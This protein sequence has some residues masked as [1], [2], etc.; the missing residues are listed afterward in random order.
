MNT[1]TILYFGLLKEEAGV[2][3]E[4]ISTELTTVSALYHNRATEHEISFPENSLKFARNEVFCDQHERINHGDT[5]AFMP[6]MAGG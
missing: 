1:V 2:T 5:V 4:T 3:E 6:P